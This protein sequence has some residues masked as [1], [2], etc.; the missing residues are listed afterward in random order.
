MSTK[1]R[2]PDKKVVENNVPEV[3]LLID[4]EQKEQNSFFDFKSLMN[5]VMENWDN[6]LEA[7][8][9]E[10][11]NGDIEVLR[12]IGCEVDV[13]REFSVPKTQYNYEF[14]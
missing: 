14:R 2:V 8:E 13:L 6:G 10:W 7:F 5:Y 4:Y 9:E 1:K 11:K 3:Y 12:V